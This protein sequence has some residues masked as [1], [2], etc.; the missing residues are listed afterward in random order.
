MYQKG[1]TIKDLSL[2]F[3]ILPQRVKAIVY[4]KHIYWNEVYPKL[5][6][7]HMRLAMEREMLYASEFPFVDYG[8]DL[9]IMSEMEKGIQLTKI[10]RS[11]SDANPPP[12]VQKKIEESLMKLKSK[13]QDHIPEKFI[14]KGGHGY[15]L[16]NWI[17]HKG[18]GAPDVTQKFKDIVNFTGT[19]KEH[20][21]SKRIKLRMMAGGPRYATMGRTR[22]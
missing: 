1:M 11:D 14:G 22:R 2:K 7:T 16:K 4:Q 12:E 15:I 13:R 9:K 6:E 21:L 8:L 19:E 20:R 3:G 17:V 5:G 10:R 18:K